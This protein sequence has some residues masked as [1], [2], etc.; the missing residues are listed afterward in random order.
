MKKICV[1]ML[2]MFA[3]TAHAERFATPPAGWQED[4]AHAAVVKA[5]TER[6]LTAPG[7][8][9]VY[10]WRPAEGGAAMIA[11]L[12]TVQVSGD[13]AGPWVRDRIESIRETPDQMGGKTNAWSEKADDKGKLVEADLQW[14]DGEQML[15]FLRTVWVR[16]VHPD[17][18][19]DVIEEYSIEC[20]LSEN[21]AS[22]FQPLCEKALRDLA[23]PAA[24]QRLAIEL[25]GKVVDPEAE[26]EGDDQPPPSD[27]IAPTPKDVEP[28]VVRQEIKPK[29]GLDLRPFYVGG[30]LLILIA[31]LLWNHKRRKEL[32]AEEEKKGE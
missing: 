17:S 16:R 3:A 32:L 30:G 25:P 7:T 26:A 29:S 22:T 31:A 23:L 5:S 21:Q 19:P 2:L 24:D 13:A 28:I 8:V 4:A 9:E 12:V 27:S 1:L 10:S 14:Y 6:A 11:S 18:A 20:L 15:T